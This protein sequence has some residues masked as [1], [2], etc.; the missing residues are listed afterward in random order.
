MC[1]LESLL[2]ELAI[3]SSTYYCS[4]YSTISSISSDS[5]SSSITFIRLFFTSGLLFVVFD[6]TSSPCLS[7]SMLTPP[8]PYSPCPFSVRHTYPKYSSYSSITC[9]YFWPNLNDDQLGCDFNST[10]YYFFYTSAYFCSGGLFAMSSYFSLFSVTAT[11]GTI[12][13]SFFKSSFTYPSFGFSVL[14]F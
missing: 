12:D 4:W 14:S 11:T 8:T 10:S 13:I 7:S 3:S 5:E 6:A 9:L 2:L 1:N